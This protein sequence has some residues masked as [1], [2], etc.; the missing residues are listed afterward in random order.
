MIHWLFLAERVGFE[1]TV[2]CPTPDFESGPLWPLRYRSTVF[3]P[4]RC[5][6]KRREKKE[7]TNGILSFQASKNPKNSRIFWAEGSEKSERFRVSP[8]MTTSIPLRVCFN[9]LLSSLKF[10]SGNFWREKQK[11]KPGNSRFFILRS[12]IYQGYPVNKTAKPA[13]NPSPGCFDRFDTAPKHPYC[14]TRKSDLQALSS[15]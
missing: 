10:H 1:P 14:T 11:R 9:L 8:V 12:L 13:Y 5:S 4:L 7:R 6:G 3:L 2:G 15:D